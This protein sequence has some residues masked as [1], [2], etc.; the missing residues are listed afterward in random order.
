LEKPASLCRGPASDEL[1]QVS[2]IRRALGI[3]HD[4]QPGVQGQAAK[5]TRFQQVTAA[6][7]GALFQEAQVAVGLEKQ[8]AG[9]QA[10]C[11]PGDERA[12]QVKEDGDQVIAPGRHRPTTQVSLD[13]L[14][15]KASPLCLG[16]GVGQPDAAGIHRRYPVAD[17][18]QIEGTA[19]K[20]TGGVQGPPPGQQVA[21]PGEQRI[22]RKVRWSLSCRVFAVPALA[23]GERH[24]QPKKSSGGSPRWTR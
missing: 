21:V 8:P 2:L 14:D 13:E 4:F 15:L 7:L 1:R 22:G 5:F 9:A 10:P 12:V 19:A 11:R 23:V 16:A 24:G 18:S 3:V 20:S 17:G 6:E